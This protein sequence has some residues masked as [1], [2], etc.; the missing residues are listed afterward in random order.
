MGKLNIE[1]CP[2]TGICSII[3]ADGAKL[4]LMPDEVDALR[5]AGNVTEGIKKALAEVDTQFAEKLDLEELKQLSSE[6]K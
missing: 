4:D 5:Q 1:L 2:E 6:L 3:K